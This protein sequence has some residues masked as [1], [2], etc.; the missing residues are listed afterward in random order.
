[1][2]DVSTPA[3]RLIKIKF[4]GNHKI[5]LTNEQLEDIDVV[6]RGIEKDFIYHVGIYRLINVCLFFVLF[7]ISIFTAKFWFCVL[8]FIFFVYNI[9]HL[10]RTYRQYKNYDGIL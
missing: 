10:Y 3:K 2:V 6:Y 8:L 1:M 5:E 4:R 9:I 7:V